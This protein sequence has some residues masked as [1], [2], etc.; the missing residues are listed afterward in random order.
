MQSKF[1]VLKLCTWEPNLTSPKIKPMYENKLTYAHAETTSL[2]TCLACL[3]VIHLFAL[4][5]ISPTWHHQAGLLGDLWRDS[6]ASEKSIT[7]F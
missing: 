6:K 3:V 2:H 1:R 5:W 7:L 4:R